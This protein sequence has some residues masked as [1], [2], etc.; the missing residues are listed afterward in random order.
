MMTISPAEWTIIVASVV[1][2]G[3]RAIGVALA[4]RVQAESRALRF[5]TCV[6]YA[7]LAALI[8]RMILQPQGGLAEAGAAARIFG[9]AAALAVFFVLKKNIAA[10]A[11]AGV[12]VFMVAERSAA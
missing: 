3:W 5:V 12:A 6:T 11:W 2:Y 9:I 7:M 8:A 10:G 1:T 4:G